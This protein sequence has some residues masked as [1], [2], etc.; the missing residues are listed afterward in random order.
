MVMQL[1]YLSRCTNAKKLV[2][3]IAGGGDI[4]GLD[5]LTQETIRIIAPVLKDL[6]SQFGDRLSVSRVSS[7][8]RANTISFYWSKPTP[9]V[10]SKFGKCKA[11]FN[12]INTLKTKLWANGE[13]DTFA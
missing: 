4:A 6:I 5:W 8:G 2:I 13:A 10:K 7:N 12:Q 11:I 9:F 1:R 3:K